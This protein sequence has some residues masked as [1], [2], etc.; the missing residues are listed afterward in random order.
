MFIRLFESPKL[1]KP[2]EFKI[3]IIS[4]LT[5]DDIKQR[6]LAVLKSI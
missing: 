5:A 1:P 6:K 2:K 3:P 4:Y